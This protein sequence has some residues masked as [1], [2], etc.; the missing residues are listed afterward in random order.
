MGERRVEGRESR[1]VDG[2]RKVEGGWDDRRVSGEEGATH[3]SDGCADKP[4]DPEDEEST[5]FV[6]KGPAN[7]GVNATLKGVEACVGLAECSTR[8]R[9]ARLT[10]AES[11]GA[12]EGWSPAVRR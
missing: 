7:A 3:G 8:F 4:E 1:W 6:G 12:S 10:H 9:G 5:E 11:P 2:G